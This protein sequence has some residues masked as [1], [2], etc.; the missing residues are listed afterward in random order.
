MDHHNRYHVDRR[1][2]SAHSS[3]QRPISTHSHSR[4]SEKE[5]FTSEYY[6]QE[7]KEQMSSRRSSRR[8]SSRASVRSGRSRQ[9]EVS[10]YIENSVVAFE[11]FGEAPT[12]L[13][14][15]EFRDKIRTSE[16]LRKNVVIKI[17]VS[18]RLIL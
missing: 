14:L 5:N 15:Y 18:F 11:E 8:S 4:R 13:K 7:I 1:R 6:L 3:R 17:E 10:R 2:R 12:S 16:K 9:P